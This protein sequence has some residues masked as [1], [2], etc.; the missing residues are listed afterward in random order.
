MAFDSKAHTAFQNNNAK[1]IHKLAKQHLGPLG[2]ERRGKGK[3]WLMDMGW[4][5]VF[6]EFLPSRH[7]YQLQVNVAA[8]L[9]WKISD[10]WGFDVMFQNSTPRLET[11]EELIASNE[12]MVEDSAKQVKELLGL[13][14][15]FSRLRDFTKASI[16]SYE[17]HKS[18]ALGIYS[19]LLRD[20]AAADEYFKNVAEF[21][22]EIEYGW[23][24]ALREM[25]SV[26]ANK[27]GDV[28]ALKEQLLEN[29]QIARKMK[30]LPEMEVQ[31]PG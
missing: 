21:P 13:M 26:L 20:K 4:Y 28:N 25:T 14:S 24:K 23:L 12:K 17:P 7:F 10:S 2:M 30:E 18:R 16:H 5:V 22:S 19:A 8:S 27:A 1:A 29:I 11:G 9:L 31:L 3:S 6:V 15:D